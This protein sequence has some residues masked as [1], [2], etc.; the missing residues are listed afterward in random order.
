MKMRRDI[1]RKD[2][3]PARVLMNPETAPTTRSSEYWTNWFSI[4]RRILYPSRTR[5]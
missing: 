4:I 3:P 5:A 2:P 1:V